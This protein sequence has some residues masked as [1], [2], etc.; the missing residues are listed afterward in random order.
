MSERDLQFS[1][2]HKR[3]FAPKPR[4]DDDQRGTVPDIAV[5]N[6]LLAP[7]MDAD[8]PVLAFTMDMLEEQDQM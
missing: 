8:D 4:P 5:N 6:E 2:S 3:F 7:Y 1:E